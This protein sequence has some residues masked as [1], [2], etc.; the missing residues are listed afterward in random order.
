MLL[1]EVAFSQQQ[2][3]ILVKNESTETVHFWFRNTK[4]SLSSNQTIKL[5]DKTW[6]GNPFY[7]YVRLPDDKAGEFVLSKFWIFA[8]DVNRILTI[9]PDKAVWLDTSVDEVKLQKYLVESARYDFWSVTRKFIRE[10]RDSEIA[11]HAIALNM[12]FS[13]YDVSTIAHHYRKLTA[14]ARTGWAADQID[15]YLA[16]RRLLS[17]GNVIPDFSL[18]DATGDTLS[19][20]SFNSKYILLYFWLPSCSPCDRLFPD[21]KELYKNTDRS[22]LEIAGIFPA[23]SKNEFIRIISEYQ[24]PWLNLHDLG[25]TYAR[26]EFA[27]SSFPTRVLIDATGKIIRVNPSTSE[28]EAFMKRK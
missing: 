18:T 8:P 2:F 22:K 12:L 26:S 28:I 10:N 3:E 17:R 20:Q 21:L 25:A 6:T 27:M 4:D 14:N 19:L 1:A 15:K 23:G 7:F 13:H 24:F 9:Q 5:I 16:G 11:A